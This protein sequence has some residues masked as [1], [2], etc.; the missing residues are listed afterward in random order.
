MI[1]Q[2]FNTYAG[3]YKSILSAFYPSKGSTGFA[4]RNLSVNW[5]KAAEIVCG[6]ENL[7]S[8]F[9]YQFSDANNKHIDALVWDRSNGNLYLIESKRF[10]DPI[11]KTKEIG[12]DVVRLQDLY[13]EILREKRIDLSKVKHCYGVILAD[14]WPKKNRKRCKKREILESFENCS[15]LADNICNFSETTQLILKDYP[16]PE[17]KYYHIVFDDVSEAERYALVSFSWRIA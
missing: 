3:I 15:F 8:W 13:E 4:E 9:E 14:V 1:D 11:S 7:I 2:I 5:S 17:L 10:S 6:R 16:F 12:N